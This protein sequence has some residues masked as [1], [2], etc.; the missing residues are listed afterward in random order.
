MDLLQWSFV[1]GSS[2]CYNKIPPTGS[3]NN[4]YL[5]LTVLEPEKS[6]IKVTA[7]SVPGEGSLPGL[8]MA[9]FLLC[10]HMAKRKREIP[11]VSLIIR[12]LIPS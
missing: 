2:G 9:V 11:L 7:N 5:V 12:V 3:L 6:K 8:Q 4:R 10:L 1:L